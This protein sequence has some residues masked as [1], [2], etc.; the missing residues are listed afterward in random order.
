[1]PSKIVIGVLNVTP[2]SF[3]DG[4]RYLDVE[5]AVAH[6]I[7]MFRAGAAIVDVGGEASNPHAAPIDVATECARVVPVIKAL[8]QVP[9]IVVSV[10]TTKAQVAEQA[11]AAGA[12]MVNDVSGGLFDSS[13][14][15]VVSRF[16]VT[17]VAGHL[18]GTNLADVFANEGEITVAEV[19]ADLEGVL[20][21]MP[22][23]LRR[24]TWVDPCLGFGK[25]AGECNWH[26]LRHS[27]HIA[28]AVGCPVLIG[29][30]RKRFLNCGAD[31]TTDTL[32]QAS[33]VASVEALT[34][35]AHAV[36]VHNVSALVTELLLASE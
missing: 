13:M 36:R 17:Y 29:A 18:R 31:A 14:I 10:D 35:G 22:A 23:E 12:T 7:A 3:S 21:R 2:N 8:S 6:G 20:G 16:A 24:R 33:V 15:D 1:M 9:G 30:S 19:I 32:D 26:L 11:I 28:N 34:C 27:G 4:G 5:A 25:G